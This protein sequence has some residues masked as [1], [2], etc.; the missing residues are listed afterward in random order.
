MQHQQAEDGEDEEGR[1]EHALEAAYL[2]LVMLL[3]QLVVCHLLL[4]HTSDHV[5]LLLQSLL[6]LVEMLRGWLL[7]L[8]VGSVDPALTWLIQRLDVFFAEFECIEV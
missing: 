2:L 4:F 1:P 5:L 3:E 8:L 6:D 7:Q